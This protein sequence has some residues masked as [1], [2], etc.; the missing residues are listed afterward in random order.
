MYTDFSNQEDLYP[1]VDGLQN[2][3][4]S[5]LGS[6]SHIALLASFTVLSWFPIELLWVLCVSMYI[7]WALCFKFWFLFDC[8]LSKEKGC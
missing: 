4:D 6:L 1:T 7:Y 5:I 3:I 2:E 8:F